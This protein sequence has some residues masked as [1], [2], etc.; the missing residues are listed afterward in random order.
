MRIIS[1]STGLEITRAAGQVASREHLLARS[2]P[3]VTRLT[4]AD[5]STAYKFT[6]TADQNRRITLEAMVFNIR[7]IEE[8]GSGATFELRRE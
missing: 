7:G 3:T 1:D 6:V 4:E 8:T 5:S 2:K